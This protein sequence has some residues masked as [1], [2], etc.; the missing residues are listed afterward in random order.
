[1]IIDNEENYHNE[2]LNP[3]ALLRRIFHLCEDASTNDAER[4]VLIHMDIEHYSIAS[5]MRL[6]LKSPYER[7]PE[8]DKG[9]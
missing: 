8:K 4:L 3:H 6:S 9:T 5:G 7:K 1:M 2:E